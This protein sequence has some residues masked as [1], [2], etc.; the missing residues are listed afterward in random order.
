MHDQIDTYQDFEFATEMNNSL[1]S[2]G[3]EGFLGSEFEG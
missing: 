3:P 2:V 1:N